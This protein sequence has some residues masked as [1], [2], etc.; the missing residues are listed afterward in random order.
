MNEV[1]KDK[2]GNILNPNIPRYDKFKNKM[3]DV[4]KFQELG[5]AVE[6]GANWNGDVDLGEYQTPE[7]YKYLGVI[8]NES[9]YGDQWQVTYARYGGNH[10]YAYVKSYYNSTLVS[11]LHCRV[12]FVK[13]DYYNIN[14]VS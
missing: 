14:K 7:G 8:T 1:L 9:G 6:I 4:F 3:D 10:I 13:E 12:I 5:K 11:S 2:D